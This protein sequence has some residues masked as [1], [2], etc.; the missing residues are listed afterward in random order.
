M[1]EKWLFVSDVDDTLLGDDVT[2]ATLM[3][4]LQAARHVLVAYNSSRP[5]AS[6]RRS[7][8]ANPLLKQPDYLI[9]ALGTEIEV[10]HSGLP[11][12]EYTAFL[13]AGWQRDGVIAVAQQLPLTPHPAEYQTPLK[14][15][16]DVPNA[17]T[18]ALVRQ[19]LNEAG[20]AAK[21]I[22]S[23]SKNLDIIPASAGKGGVIDYLHRSLN[24]A[25]KQVAV[26]GDSGNDT[27]MFIAPYCGIVVGNADNDLRRLNG[28]HIYKAN[29]L[30]A[31]GVLEGLRY[32][33]VIG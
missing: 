13:G 22:F 33:G 9:G 21:V 28:A 5:C 19:R 24:I 18:A 12:T 16:F 2:L 3:T 31:A 29:N 14:A 6:L 15:S 11:M 20:L 25:A 4:A 17:E 32:W 23:G 27:E 1:T 26:A 7:M 30:Y 10:G 8:A